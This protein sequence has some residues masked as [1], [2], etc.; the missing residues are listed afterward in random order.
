VRDPTAGVDGR[1]FLELE[2]TERRHLGDDRLLPPGKV[3]FNFSTAA[4]RIAELHLRIG[5]LGA[6]PRDRS[7]IGGSW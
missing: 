3:E 1:Q 5:V 6:A 2:R 4:V 7:T